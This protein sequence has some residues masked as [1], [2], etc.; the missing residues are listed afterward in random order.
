MSP[1]MKGALG[2]LGCAGIFGAAYA[3]G[4]KAGREETLKEVEQEERKMAEE[5][6]QPV[7]IREVPVP[8]SPTILPVSEPAKI[9]VS[10]ML[11]AVQETAA[12]RVRNKKHGLRNKL[13]S[14]ANV[15]KDLF[16]DPDGKKLIVTVED[17][18]VVARLSQKGA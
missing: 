3:I 7:V 6:S 15:I 13:F 2:F 14:G 11:P 5:P 9:E 12:E 10:E 1:F 8:Q 18:D 17:G 16:G 4:K